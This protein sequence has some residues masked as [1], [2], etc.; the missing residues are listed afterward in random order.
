MYL[1]V[2]DLAGGRKKPHVAQNPGQSGFVGFVLMGLV[3]AVA[4]AEPSPQLDHRI[5]G[6]TLD[7]RR[8]PSPGLYDE[9]ADLGANQVALVPY[10]FLRDGELRFN[11]EA[12]WFSESASGTAALA[13]SLRRRG[14]GITIKPQLWL[15]NERFPGDL[16]FPDEAG[17]RRFEEG[18]RTYALHHARLAADV[19]AD[20]Y[21]VGTELARS[22]IERPEFWRSLIAEVRAEYPGKLT[23]AANWWAEVD[24]IAFWDDLDAIGVQAY[25]P[26]ADTAGT[27]VPALTRRWR[28]HGRTLAGLA[29]QWNRPIVFTE[30]GYRSM[31]DAAVR[32]WEWTPRRQSQNPD[33]KAQAD[34]YRAFFDAPW[35]ASWMGGAY[36]WKWYGDGASPRH[37]LDFTPQGKPAE[38]IIREA[39]RAEQ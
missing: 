27:E 23:Y 6:V 21:V 18:Y 17:W 3:F 11:P 20:W 37:A 16:T 19:G 35:R 38:Q 28:A 24:S 8:T 9:L 34:L 2:T 33:P 25:Y 10:A 7:A 39:F 4:L 36:I 30:I 1:K 22:A 15:G 29:R 26:L 14:I 5:T 31:S 12:R 32:P 13:D